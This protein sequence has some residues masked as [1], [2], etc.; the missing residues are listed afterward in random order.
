MNNNIENNYLDSGMAFETTLNKQL[1][2]I[3]LDQKRRR[4]TQ[5]KKRRTIKKWVYIFS[6]CR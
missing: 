1:R 2:R 5:E 4:N 6:C 3:Y